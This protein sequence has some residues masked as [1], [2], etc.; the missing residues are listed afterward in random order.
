[1]GC[2][3]APVADIAVLTDDALTVIEQR[4][5]PD[6]FRDLVAVAED[7]RRRLAEGGP[8]A[9]TTSA[10]AATTRPTTARCS[11]PRRT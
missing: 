6:L 2:A 8:F 4:A 7:F 9:A 11:R 3:G 1:M 5:D 10:S